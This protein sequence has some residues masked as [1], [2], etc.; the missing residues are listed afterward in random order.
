MADPDGREIFSFSL[1]LFLLVCI[2]S[3]CDNFQR[4]EQKDSVLEAKSQN[5]ENEEVCL[6]NDGTD[7][8][9]SFHNCQFQTYMQCFHLCCRI[10]SI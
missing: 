5:W 10:H 1:L 8:I 3:L 2:L 7:L 6:I 9:L 4:H